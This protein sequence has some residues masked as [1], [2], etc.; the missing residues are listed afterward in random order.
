MQLLV[1]IQIINNKEFKI[2][3]YYLSNFIYNNS[4]QK[5]GNT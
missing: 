4:N 1:L 3:N 2:F 5:I